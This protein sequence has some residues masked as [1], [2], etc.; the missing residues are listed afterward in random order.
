VERPHWKSV[1][2]M[3]FFRTDPGRQT[4]TVDLGVWGKRIFQSAVLPDSHSWWA[5]A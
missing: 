5:G 3:S 4:K 2:T 1:N